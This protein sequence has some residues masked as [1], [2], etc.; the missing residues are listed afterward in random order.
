MCRL[1]LVDPTQPHPSP[2]F[3]T[4]TI[5]RAALIAGA[6]SGA[7]TREGG[8]RSGWRGALQ[9]LRMCTLA[10]DHCL[11]VPLHFIF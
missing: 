9:T 4:L 7:S 3:C 8:D 6:V 2:S 11:S 5:C 10:G 1:L